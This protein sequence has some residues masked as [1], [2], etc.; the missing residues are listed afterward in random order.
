MYTS[1]N[2]SLLRHNYLSQFTIVN[3]GVISPILFNM[4]M[5]DLS[6]ALNNSGIGGYL[7]D[8]FF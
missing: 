8:A 4:C 3:G 7:G 2:G 5:D 6:I 1:Q